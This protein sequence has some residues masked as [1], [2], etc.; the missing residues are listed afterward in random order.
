MGRT[1]WDGRVPG[2]EGPG[3]RGG[4]RGP[5]RLAIS[6][7][8]IA[9]KMGVGGG[10]RTLQLLF[11]S[12]EEIVG[13]TVALHSE[14]VRLRDRVLV[15]AVDHPSWATQLRLLTP[16]MLGRLHQLT[17]DAVSTVEITVR[18]ARMTGP[19]LSS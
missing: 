9:E 11:S 8:A 2:S 5:V 4:G 18:R 13:R 17:G 19:N 12:W 16:T 3:R 7:G 6:L 15:V 10:A 14:P 1:G